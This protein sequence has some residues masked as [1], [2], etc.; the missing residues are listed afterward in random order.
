MFADRG[1]HSRRGLHGSSSEKS[2]ISEQRAR[3][4]KGTIRLSGMLRGNV[5]A[6]RRLEASGQAPSHPIQKCSSK[7]PS[8][9]LRRATHAPW[10]R[11]EAFNAA[12]LASLTR[13]WSRLLD[14]AA[15][16]LPNL[17]GHIVS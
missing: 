6:A 5:T 11:R 16:R 7:A 15:S 12:G 8:A 3:P 4:G 10:R 13:R 14:L 1:E 2:G 17:R 9:V